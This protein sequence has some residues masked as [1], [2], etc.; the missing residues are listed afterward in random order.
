M[1]EVNDFAEIVRPVCPA[2]RVGRVAADAI[3]ADW[4]FIDAARDPIEKW[5]RFAEV[6]LQEGQRLRFEIAPRFNSELVHFRSGR[7][8]DAMEFFD[9]QRL[10]KEWPILGVMTKR[11][12][13]L[14]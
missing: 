4:P 9:R 13:G 5:P 6:A 3:G 1:V 8:A 14:R 2:I 12:L 11:P 10:D 7:R